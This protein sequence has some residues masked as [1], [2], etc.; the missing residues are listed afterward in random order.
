MVVSVMPDSDSEFG[1]DFSLEEEELMLQL[2]QDN[3]TTTIQDT[4][5]TTASSTTTTTTTTTFGLALDSKR[6]NASIVTQNG[7]SHQIASYL[8]DATSS[9]RH[10]LVTEDSLS[11]DDLDELASDSDLRSLSPPLSVIKDVQYPN[12]TRPNPHLYHIPWFN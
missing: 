1:Y 7:Y 4:S 5:I 9:T 11:V 3:H 10:S 2:D 6:S 8:A 12:C